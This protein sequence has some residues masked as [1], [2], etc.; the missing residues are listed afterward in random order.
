MAL[1]YILSRRPSWLPSF[2]SPAFPAREAGGVEVRGPAVHRVADLAPSGARAVGCFDGVAN[3][4][5][6]FWV[7][8]ASALQWSFSNMP[9]PP[10]RSP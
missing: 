5:A 9:P 7:P 2:D 8:I 1:R 3:M 10:P 4:D 6:P